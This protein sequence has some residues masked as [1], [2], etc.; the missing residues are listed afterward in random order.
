[1]ATKKPTKTKS[2]PK[3]KVKEKV[4]KPTEKEIIQGLIDTAGNLVDRVIL[5]E[6]RLTIV[7]DNG[8]YACDQIQEIKDKLAVVAGRLGL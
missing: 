1:M 2:K 8:Q 3:T 4:K 6:E 5:L 7:N